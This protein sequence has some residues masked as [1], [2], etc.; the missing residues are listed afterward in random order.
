MDVS[1]HRVSRSLP[2]FHT[3]FEHRD[4]LKAL[5]P[6]FRCPTDSGGFARSS[7]IEDDFLRLWQRLYTRLEA[8]ERYRAFQVEHPAFGLVL[9]GAN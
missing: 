4:V 2:R 8:D 9:I 6:V 7:S 1:I 3:A 5:R